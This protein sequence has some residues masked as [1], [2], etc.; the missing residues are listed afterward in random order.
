MLSHR[1]ARGKRWQTWPVTLDG[2][3]ETKDKECR[4]TVPGRVPA[5]LAEG[6]RGRGSGEKA[7]ELRLALLSGA[8]GPWKS[9][10]HTPFPPLSCCSHILKAAVKIDKGAGGQS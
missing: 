9:H 2:A 4:K 6:W 5:R 10:L 8:E 3:E 1:L 7:G